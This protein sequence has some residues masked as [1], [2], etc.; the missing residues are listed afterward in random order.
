MTIRKLTLP[1][2]ALIAVAA[3]FGTRLIA[4]AS[5]QA[6]TEEQ[7]KFAYAVVERNAEPPV[8]LN[9]EMMDKYRPEMKKHYLNKRPVFK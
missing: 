2:V 9:K 1:S 5:A 6:A 7:K 8:E 4:P 3:L